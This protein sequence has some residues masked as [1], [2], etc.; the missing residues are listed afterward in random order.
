M[1]RR[2]RHASSLGDELRKSVELFLAHAGVA[3]A[4]SFLASFVLL[5]R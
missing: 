3:L 2:R 1:A 4:L 5:A